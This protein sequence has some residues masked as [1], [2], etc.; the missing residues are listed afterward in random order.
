MDEGQFRI[1]RFGRRFWEVRDPQGELVCICV[2]KKGALE[3]V[4]RLSLPAR[5]GDS[6]L[7]E[8]L[9]AKQSQN[10]VSGIP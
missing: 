1:N 5:D 7:S 4:R 6:I 3:V 10:D 9:P 8:A 2:Y